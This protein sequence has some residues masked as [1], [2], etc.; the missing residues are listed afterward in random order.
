MSSFGPNQLWNFH[1]I[2][3]RQ[4]F[5]LTNAS[6]SINRQDLRELH[7][8]TRYDQGTC[9]F[10]WWPPINT[11]TN[12]H[13]NTKIHVLSLNISIKNIHNFWN[14]KQKIFIKNTKEGKLQLTN[15]SVPINRQDLRELHPLT[16]PRKSTCFLLW[17]P[18]NT[19]TNKHNNTKIHVLSLNKLVSKIY[20]TFGTTNFN[21]H[22]IR[23]RQKLSTYKRV[24]ADK[25]PKLQLLG[26]Y[27]LWLICKLKF[28]FFL[29]F[30]ENLVCSKVVIIFLILICLT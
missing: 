24:S 3:Q 6:V 8:L 5:Q 28:S 12:N 20:S 4:K 2:R 18:I 21:F 29:C 22:K 14:N 11:R 30:H 17:W 25:L 26:I 19:R 7:P 15:A 23:Q 13:N 9:F 27:R 1:K 16:G 10:I